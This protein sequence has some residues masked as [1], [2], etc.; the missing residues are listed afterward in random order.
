MKVMVVSDSHGRR[1]LFDRM[2]SQE[3]DCKDV[4]FL[5]DGMKDIEIMKEFYP[6]KKFT[7]VRGNNDW[8]YTVSSEAYK[9]FDGVTVFACHGDMYDVRHTLRSVFKKA[10]SVQAGLALYG[11]THIAY[12]TKDPLTGVVAINPGAVCEGRYCVIEFSKGSFKAESK[13][14]Y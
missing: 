14:C 8:D 9:Y 1:E 10:A 3:P 7:C 12:E 5:G 11:H 2:L 6:D 13:S 4:I